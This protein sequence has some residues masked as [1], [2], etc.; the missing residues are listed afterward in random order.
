[1]AEMRLVHA[2]L[3][4]YPV[5]SVDR[6][7]GVVQGLSEEG[8]VVRVFR[9]VSHEPEVVEEPF[10]VGWAVGRFDDHSVE[11]GGHPSRAQMESRTHHRS[12]GDATWTGSIVRG[13]HSKPA[14]VGSALMGPSSHASPA[15]PLT[16]GYIPY[17]IGD[18]SV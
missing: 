9:V 17:E 11:P 8:R 18:F 13:V 6:G 15:T 5:E 2:M 7:A 14:I 3:H 4:P 16:W 1:V 12:P 10:H